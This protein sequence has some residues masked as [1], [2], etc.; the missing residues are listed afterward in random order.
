[1]ESSTATPYEIAERRVEQRR[2]NPIETIK[3]IRLRREAVVLAGSVTFVA[4]ASAAG[5]LLA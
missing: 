4:A 1:V 5:A 3:Q 2:R